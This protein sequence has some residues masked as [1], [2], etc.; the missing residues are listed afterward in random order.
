MPP[1]MWRKS[2]KAVFSLASGSLLIDN[3]EADS[4]KNEDRQIPQ[5]YPDFGNGPPANELQ[6]REEIV[7]IGE[8]PCITRQVAGL[9]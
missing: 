5:G 1:T 3:T 9:D 8:P 7:A 2:F 4:P 6:G